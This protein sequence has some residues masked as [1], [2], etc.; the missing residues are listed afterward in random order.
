M[1]VFTDLSRTDI[2]SLL[3][4]YD[5]GAY[6]DHQGISAGTENTNF[7]V[8]TDQHRFVLT[9]FEKHAPEEL[10]F[11]LALGEH[12]HDDRCAVPQ[13]FRTRDG[14]FLISA[15]GKPA[16]LFECVQ[17]RHQ[18]PTPAHARTLAEALAD[19]HRS[20]ARF[21]SRR[22]H[23]HGID[24]IERTA[25]ELTGSFPDEDRRLLDQALEC[26]AGIDRALPSGV[27]HAD[28][29]HDNAMFEGDHLAGIIDWYFA[30]VDLYA[31]DIAVCLIDWCLDED[32]GL[33][34]DRCV[35]FVAHYHSHR[36]LK[37]VEIDAI[38]A[39]TAQ[40]ATRFWLS[41]ALAVRDNPPQ[42]GVT[43]KDPKAMKALTRH[44]LKLRTEFGQVLK[45]QLS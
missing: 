31:L 3:R 14:D 24:W 40:A 13:P 6:R 38:P 19:I 37:A 44:S 32:G 35:D 1:S 8:D 39:L 41:R 5:L 27:I 28:L 22:P 26:L 7:F 10:P 42:D 23:S 2:E 43:I 4:H 15:K 11:F 9:L 36:T 29:F 16:V 45:K 18:Q 20:T 33:D 34:L 12:L 30:G 21:D 25:R 17:G